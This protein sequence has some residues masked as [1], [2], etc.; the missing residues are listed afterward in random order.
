MRKTHLL[1][2]FIVLAILNLAYAVPAVVPTFGI[3]R[4][5]YTGV[6][7]TYQAHSGTNTSLEVV[8]TGDIPWRLS[9]VTSSAGTTTV[10]RVWNYER[11]IYKV[12]V[13][14]NFFGNVETNS[15]FSG[16]Q[17]ITSTNQMYTS[18]SPS[19]PSSHRMIQH[20]MLL[21]DF[22]TDTGVVVRVVGTVE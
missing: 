13:S 4:Q 6:V 5:Q 16:A 10:Y 15:Y 12:V 11:P 2:T 18:T 8:Y 20:D 7:A 19:L 21:L 14:T 22:G 3:H 9:D 1:I 17:T